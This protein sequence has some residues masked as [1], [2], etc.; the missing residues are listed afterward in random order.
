MLDGWWTQYSQ[1]SFATS[2]TEG[3]DFK[4]E[5]KL[6]SGSVSAAMHNWILGSRLLSAAFWKIITALKSHMTSYILNLKYFLPISLTAIKSFKIVWK[7][8][9]R[10]KYS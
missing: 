5:I 6:T 4:C 10:V 7:A 8:S 3:A 9:N 2:Q 1:F